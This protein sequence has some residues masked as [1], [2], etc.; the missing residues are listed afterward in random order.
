MI[1]DSSDEDIDFYYHNL[2]GSTNNLNRDTNNLNINNS[3]NNIDNKKLII[4]NEVSSEN[5][6]YIN[7]DNLFNV[8]IINKDKDKDKDKIVISPTCII[9]MIYAFLSL[10]LILSFL[11]YPYYLPSINNKT[12]N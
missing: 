1:P 3:L 6:K 7:K 9:T 10:F 4:A 2:Y 12:N 5:K 8:R 11:L